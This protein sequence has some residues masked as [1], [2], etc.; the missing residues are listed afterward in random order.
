MVNYKE[1]TSSCYFISS[2]RESTIYLSWEDSTDAKYSNLSLLPKKIPFLLQ[3]QYA[4]RIQS[5]FK[6]VGLVF[7]SVHCC[8]VSCYANFRVQSFHTNVCFIFKTLPKQNSFCK[9]KVQWNDYRLRLELVKDDRDCKQHDVEMWC[10]Q[11]LVKWSLESYKLT[12]FWVA[13]FLRI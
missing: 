4:R 12:V 2:G 5:E 13:N 10:K 11:R 3:W 8:Q 1:R 6:E 7:Y 9:R